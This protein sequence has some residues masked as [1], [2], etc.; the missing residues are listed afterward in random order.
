M[1][2]TF[3]IAKLSGSDE[4]FDQVKAKL[5][6]LSLVLDYYDVVITDIGVNNDFELGDLMIAETYQIMD[7][8]DI[9]TKRLE[10]VRYGTM[11]CPPCHTGSTGPIGWETCA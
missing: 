5:D 6:N 3:N 4:L 8:I 9:M 1:G 10:Q 7:I 11:A 2:L